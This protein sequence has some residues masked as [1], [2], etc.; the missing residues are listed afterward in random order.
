M[1]RRTL[2]VPQAHASLPVLAA[3]MHAAKVVDGDLQTL[4]PALD[5]CVR[6]GIVVRESMIEGR[7]KRI[8]AHVAVVLFERSQPFGVPL[9]EVV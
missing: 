4:A 2:D 9:W 1:E 7:V 5:G 6:R 8:D 3:E